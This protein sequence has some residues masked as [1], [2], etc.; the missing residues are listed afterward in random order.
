MEDI[1]FWQYFEEITD[2]S[3][4]PFARFPRVMVGCAPRIEDIFGCFLLGV[5]GVVADPGFSR[6]SLKHDEN[7]STIQ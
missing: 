6:C 1:F 5:C 3:L 7:R 4:V 2:L